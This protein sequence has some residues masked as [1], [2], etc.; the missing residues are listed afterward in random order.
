MRLSQHRQKEM[1]KKLDVHRHLMDLR[2]VSKGSAG[3]PPKL[4]RGRSARPIRPM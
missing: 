4:T 3:L 1:R 2:F